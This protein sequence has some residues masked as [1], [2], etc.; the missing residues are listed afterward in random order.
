MY[1]DRNK[2]AAYVYWKKLNDGIRVPREEYSAEGKKLL[3]KALW[4]AFGLELQ[5]EEIAVGSC[6]KP[7]LVQH[8]EIH[9]NISHSG[10]YVVCA[11]S[12]SEVGIDIQEKRVIALDKIGRKIF[13]PEEYREFLKSEEKQDIFFRQWVRIESYLKWTGEGITRKLTDLKMDGWHQFLHMNKH[14]MCAIW[15]QGPLSIIMREL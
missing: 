8:P 5:K 13:S 6:G 2:K 12:G 11:V 9:Y 4:D 7:Y 3:E 14:Y 1:Q 10:C 15:S